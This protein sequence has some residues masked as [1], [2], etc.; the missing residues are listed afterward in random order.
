MGGNVPAMRFSSL[1]LA[2][3]LLAACATPAPTAP[4]STTPQA[5]TPTPSPS[6]VAAL[7][8]QAGRADAPTQQAVEALLGQPDLARQD[9]AGAALTYRFE[10]CALLLLF[11]ADGR[12]AM[13][14]AQ[15]HPS[16][17]RSGAEAP[18]LAQCAAE[19]DVRGS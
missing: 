5:T 6:R 9:G 2:A 12:N 19:A 14:L 3:A 11:T 1:I 15:A 8:G 13:R 7:L 17:R 16:A 18:S 4:G 10:Q